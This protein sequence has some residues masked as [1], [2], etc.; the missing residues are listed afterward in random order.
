VAGLSRGELVAGDPA[1]VADGALVVGTLRIELD[2]AHEPAPPRAQDLAPRWRAALA[3][4]LAAVAPAPP[5]LAAGLEL[6]AAGDLAA[7]VARLAGRGDGLTP[8]GDD[9]LAGYAAWRWAEGAPVALPGQRCAPLGRAY[10]HCAERGELPEPAAR[11]L[12]AIRAGEPQAAARRAS[13]LAGWGATS[14]AALLWGMA[15]AAP[16]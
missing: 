7:A 14:G 2:G 5:E 15:A 6:L 13:G 4:A 1:Q 12:E 9:V 10:L 3:A 11:V 8:T 16:R